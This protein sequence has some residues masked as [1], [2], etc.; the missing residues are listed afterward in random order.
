MGTLTTGTDI[1]DIEMVLNTSSLINP[2]ASVYHYPI[3]GGPPNVTIRDSSGLAGTLELLCADAVTADSVYAAH[4]D[5]QVL[6]LDNWQRRNM[7]IDPRA[8]SGSLWNASFGT[9]GAGTETAVTGA[10]DGPLLPDGTMVTTYMRFTWTDAA[11]SGS[12]FLGA[13]N[14]LTYPVSPTIPAGPLIAAAIYARPSV[15]TAQM[16]AR[17]NKGLN[18]ANLAD[19]NV[20]TLTTPPANVW[21]RLS[22]TAANP[23]AFNQAGAV[24]MVANPAA[25]PVGGTLDVTC[26]L[27]V[28]DTSTVPDHFDGDTPGTDTLVNAWAGAPNASVSNQYVRPALD[29]TYLAAGVELPRK[30]SMHKYLVRVTG[31]QEVAP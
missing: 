2:N 25:F 20:G 6:R 18:G 26:A 5:G 3:G 1:L 16:L 10:L 27:V 8:T 12:A 21:T 28:P 17:V 31:F 13:S 19:Q 11:E 24:A 4:L 30:V 15:A 9:G 29:L 23:V 22:G 7:V 14:E